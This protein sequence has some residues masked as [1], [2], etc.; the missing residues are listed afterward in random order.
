MKAEPGGGVCGDDDAG[1]A[2]AAISCC[3]AARASVA[4]SPNVLRFVAPPPPVVAPSKAVR[5]GAC[6][7][8]RGCWRG[9]SCAE[10]Q[11]LGALTAGTTAAAAPVPRGGGV[12]VMLPVLALVPKPPSANARNDSSKSASIPRTDVEKRRGAVARK[13]G[14]SALGADGRGREWRMWRPAPGASG[15][16]AG[17]GIRGVSCCCCC[18][19][20]CW[21]MIAVR[22]A[23]SS[24]GSAVPRGPVACDGTGESTADGGGM[25]GADRVTGVEPGDEAIGRRAGDGGPPAGAAGGRASG[26]KQG[27]GALPLLWGGDK[28]PLGIRVGSGPTG[29]RGDGCT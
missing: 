18:C 29:T 5:V 1:W 28:A 7:C 26:A 19:C 15:G 17:T 25:P 4:A 14:A 8:C 22:A 27:E 2:A 13:K 12:A 20:C 6:G 21:S 23:I 24:P 9:S 11:S 10:G 16:D 3:K